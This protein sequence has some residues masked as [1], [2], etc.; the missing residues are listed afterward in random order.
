MGGHEV[1]LSHITNIQYKQAIE[2]LIRNYK[3]QKTLEVG[4]EMNL[5]LQDDLPGYE[6]PRRLYP[7]YKVEVNGQIKMWLK[8]GII[9]QSHSD[10]AS[11][12]ALVNKK[13]MVQLE[14][15]SIIGESKSSERQVPA[16]PDR[17]SIRFVT[18]IESIQYVGPQER[19]HSCSCRRK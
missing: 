7:Q 1:D 3:P 5:I 11:P 2:N 19:I 17:G 12:I 6:R 8:D 15:A 13:K 9:C 16:T 4:V 14:F 10:Y 18:G